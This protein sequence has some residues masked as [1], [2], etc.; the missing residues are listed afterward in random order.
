MLDTAGGS[1]SALMDSPTGGFRG[2][3]LCLVVFLFF[4]QKYQMMKIDNFPTIVARTAIP[5]VAPCDMPDLARLLL[6][7]LIGGRSELVNPNSLHSFFERLP[8][9]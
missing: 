4:Q 9:I 2:D 7:P 8:S 6:E 5:M 1:S 3:G